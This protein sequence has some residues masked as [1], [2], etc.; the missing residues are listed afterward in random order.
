MSAE[1]EMVLIKTGPRTVQVATDRDAELLE[2]WKI[3]Q[4]VRVKPVKVKDRVL[5]HHQLY[6]SGLLALALD[7][8]EPTGGLISSAESLILEKYS[9]WVD[10]QLENPE[11]PTAFYDLSKDYIKELTESRAS[12]IEAPGKSI[13]ALHRFVKIEA[14]YFDIEE[15]PKGLIK[16]AKSINFN[17]M[18]QDEFDAYYKEAFNVCWRFILSRTFKSEVEADTAV[19]ELLRILN[20]R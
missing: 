6:W 13:E 18:N 16:V 15:T 2:R 8:W 19:N 20:G 11:Y 17:S 9:K 5:E 10:K 1:N 12:K 4:G 14:G 3:G 7:Y